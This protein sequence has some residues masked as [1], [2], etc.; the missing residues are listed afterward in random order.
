MR[1]APPGAR[2]PE[3]GGLLRWV[4]M[5]SAPLDPAE[6]RRLR[7]LIRTDRAAAGKELSALPI[8]LQVEFVC[9][10]PVEQRATLLSLLD[11]PEQVIPALPEAE[12]CFTVK[13]VG[14]HDAG[15][16]LDHARPEQVVAALDLDAWSG[17]QLEPSTLAEWIEALATTDRPALLRSLS[18]IDPELLVLFLKSRI[19]AVQKP[20]DDEGFEPPAGAQSLEGQFH[21]VARNEGD[22]LAPVIT[23]LRALFEEDYWY[24]FRLMQGV[25]WE[26]ESDASEW[27]IRWRSGRLEDLGFPPWE[28]AMRIYRFVPPAERAK[29]DED[30]RPLDVSAWS[31]PVWL[32]SLPAG[33]DARHRIFRAVA[34]LSDDER[35]ACFYAFTALANRIAV[36]D[37]LPLSDA[38]STPRALEKA[39]R[40]TSDGLAHLAEQTGLQDVEVLRRVSLERLF[41]VG[42]NLDPESAHP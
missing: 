8:D 11:Q 29:L 36:A 15:W 5:A 19:H 33:A 10:T 4:V 23:V 2:R 38:E 20:T 27:A 14:L 24:Y 31:A 9:S 37:R 13:A 42:A 1:S 17:H 16:I 32:P 25:V 18:A 22:D 12:L 30:A 28:D 40:F 26:L 34:E 7:R 35:H 6:S 21:L 3:R 39:A 41:S